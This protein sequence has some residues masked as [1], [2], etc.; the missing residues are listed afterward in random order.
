MK[1]IDRVLPCLACTEDE[2]CTRASI[3]GDREAEQLFPCEAEQQQ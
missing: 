3:M 1:N 2:N